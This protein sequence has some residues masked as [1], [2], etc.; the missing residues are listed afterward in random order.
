M[1]VKYGGL[2]SEVQ[3]YTDTIICIRT[4]GARRVM[5]EHAQHTKLCI[6][7]MGA[8]PGCAIIPNTTNYVY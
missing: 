5:C 3:A 7:T 6:R 2:V 4:L 1:C 8:R